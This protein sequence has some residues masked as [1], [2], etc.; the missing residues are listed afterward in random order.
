MSRF[1]VVFTGIISARYNDRG[2]PGEHQEGHWAFRKKS[3]RDGNPEPVFINDW[4]G[5][6]E[7]CRAEGLALPKEFGR[8]FEVSEDGRTVKNSVGMP[9]CE[10]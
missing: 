9:G 1:A 8:N 4:Q 10:I 3:S 2:I 5:Q 6:R 7:F